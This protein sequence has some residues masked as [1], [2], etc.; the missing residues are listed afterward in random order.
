MNTV[1]K[2]KEY[3]S[4]IDGLRA[5][6]ILSVLFF[7]INPAWLPG[8]FIGVDVFF[9][10]SGFLI[11]S[12]I[13]SEIESQNG[14]EFGRFYLRRIQRILPALFFMISLVLL[15]SYFIFTQSYFHTAGEQ[16]LT[17]V[18]SFSNIYF[19]LTSGYFDL[20]ASLKPLLHTW[21]LGVEEQFYLLWPLIL[22]LFTKVSRR[23][24]LVLW[25]FCVLIL[26]SFLLNI[27]F[28]DSKDAIF[29]LMPFRI[30]EF[31]VGAVVAW[32]VLR[33]AS[34][35]YSESVGNVVGGV[36]LA[37][38]LSM[39]FFLDEESVFPSYNAIPVIVA[40]ALILYYQG[41]LVSKLLSVKWLV[42]VG[43]ISYSLY[44][45]HWPVIVFARYLFPMQSIYMLNITIVILSFLLAV[46]SYFYIERPLRY[47]KN[48]NLL[49][50]FIAFLLATL[51]VSVLV[52]SKRI[53][54]YNYGKEIVQKPL[55]DVAVERYS[56]LNKSGCNIETEVSSVMCDWSA[57]HQ[58]LFVGNSHNIDA[59]NAFY[60]VI[61]TDEKYN[62]I[63]SGD[64][65]KCQYEF[66]GDQVVSKNNNCKYGAEQ[67][68]SSR[69]LTKI[70]TLVVNFYKISSHGRRHLKLISILKRFNPDVNVIV[71]GGYIGLRPNNCRELVNKSGD[72]N[73]CKEKA[74]VTHWGDAER[75]W[76]ISQDF[77]KSNFLY[78]DRVR[79]LCGELRR[80]SDCT[81]HV[82]NELIVYDGDHFSLFGSVYFGRKMFDTYRDE[83]DGFLFNKTAP[84]IDL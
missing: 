22:V 25:L 66:E 30:F 24:V 31:S 54:S 4:D 77:S 82:G 17:A 8:G 70:D 37:V 84:M 59:Y 64:T 20:D 40:S 69:F 61:G 1:N 19:Y 44:L 23:S 68:S 74:Y 72:L 33:G 80:L 10:I 47:T 14:F 50:V 52:F 38:L 55:K 45:Y 71:I 9:V 18:L 6:A 49:F 12:H 73:I 27:I 5:V 62:L 46:F 51:S 78:V 36:S 53:N 42:F 43:L 28:G 34:Y 15:V 11:S 7:H 21:S 26:I 13:M 83:F 39:M 2:N 65:H 48:K 32:F 41:S 16:A 57:N 56:Q 81:V 29:Y 35:K 63:F 58:I 67:I 60:E 75:E 76:T 3:R 79:L